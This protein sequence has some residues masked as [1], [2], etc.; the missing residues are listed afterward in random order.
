MWGPVR[1]NTA[2]FTELQGRCKN[3]L[4]QLRSPYYTWGRRLALGTYYLCATLAVESSDN[5]GF[6]S[7]ESPANELGSPGESWDF[8]HWWLLHKVKDLCN[9][10][11]SLVAH[12]RCFSCWTCTVSVDGLWLYIFFLVRSYLKFSRRIIIPLDMYMLVFAWLPYNCLITFTVL[13]LPSLQFNVNSLIIFSFFSS[14]L[15][16]YLPLV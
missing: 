16:F 12:L 15:R 14:P 1:Y 6:L 3:L 10:P 7:L 2:A 8:E 4:I 13:R 5:D 9:I 11:L